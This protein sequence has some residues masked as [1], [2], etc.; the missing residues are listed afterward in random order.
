[1]HS[2]L[3]TLLAI[4]SKAEPLN[5][6]WTFFSNGTIT[7]RG[8][9][10]LKSR[11]KISECKKPKNIPLT[12]N[13]SKSKGHPLMNGLKYHNGCNTMNFTHT[14]TDFLFNSPTIIQPIKKMDQWKILV[15]SWTT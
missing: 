13:A 7:L 9:I 12:K 14:K 3:K 4:A 1:M 10:L 11:N 6:S 15:N 5:S 8:S 2:K